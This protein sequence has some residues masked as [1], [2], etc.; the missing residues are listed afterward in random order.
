MFVY[1][2]IFLNLYRFLKT[3][4]G[5]VF[6]L[7]SDFFKN[8]YRFFFIFPY[9][10]LSSVLYQSRPA[11]LESVINFAMRIFFIFILGNL[12]LYIAVT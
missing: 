10:F 4:R 1:F 7:F 9:F 12:K 5:P 6:F 11:D 3:C 8:L 2:Q